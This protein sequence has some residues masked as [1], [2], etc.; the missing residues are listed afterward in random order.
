M[1]T[2]RF[3]VDFH[4]DAG[5]L[6]LDQDAVTN[7][8]SVKAG[9]HSKTHDSGWTITGELHE[10]RFVWVS[11]FY[12]IHDQYGRIEGDFENEVTAESEEAFSHFLK[13]HKPIAWN[14]GD[15]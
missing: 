8:A 1:I 4:S 6:T 2:K 9:E 15:I 14:Y 5:A 12:A 10:N 11:E 7:D 3:G 13:H